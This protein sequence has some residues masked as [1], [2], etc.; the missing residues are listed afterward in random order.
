MRMSNAIVTWDWV[1]LIFAVPTGC[2]H[3]WRHGAEFDHGRFASNG[4]AF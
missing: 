2:A 1:W 4:F 3:A